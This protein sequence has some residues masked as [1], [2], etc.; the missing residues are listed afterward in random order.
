MCLRWAVF[1]GLLL[2]T[3][4]FPVLPNPLPLPAVLATGTVDLVVQ[5]LIGGLVG[6][7]LFLA[8]YYVVPNRPMRWG[9]IWIGAAMAGVLFEALSLVFPLYLRLTGAG[10]GYGKTFG[11]LFLLMI[12]F[13]YIGILTMVGVE[14]N[15]LLYPVPIDQPDGRESLV[16]PVQQGAKPEPA[17]VEAPI[18]DPG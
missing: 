9:S 15:S 2:F 16:T 10:T 8:I 17:P 3:A 18:D 14:V 6:F 4:S 13:Y 1:G 7:A 11:L 12:Y 5:V